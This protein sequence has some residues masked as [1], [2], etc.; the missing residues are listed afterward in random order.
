VGWNDAIFKQAGLILL[1]PLNLDF[2][3]GG[4]KSCRYSFCH[5][6]S[7]TVCSYILLYTCSSYYSYITHDFSHQLDYFQP[8]EFWRILPSNKNADPSPE[9]AKFTGGGNQSSSIMKT[10]IFASLLLIFS[11]QYSFLNIWWI[12]DFSCSIYF[13][14]DNNRYSSIITVNL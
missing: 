13:I 12:T 14:P 2:I 7:C 1:A 6:F 5:P 8:I 11:A 3:I 10:A 4:A 9:W